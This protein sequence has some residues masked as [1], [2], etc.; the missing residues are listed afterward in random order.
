MRKSFVVCAA[1]LGLLLPT[2]AQ[3]DVFEATGDVWLREVG[4]GTTFENDWVSVWS[5]A[6]ND[7][8]VNG[9]RYGLIEWD[10]SSL[11]GQSLVGA[12]LSLWVGNDF[13]GTGVPIKMS[14]FVIDTTGKTPLLNL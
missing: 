12:K 8:G 1:M 9:R 6:T 11:A 10:V 13:S 5:A 4:G 7:G 2:M 14:A 3:A